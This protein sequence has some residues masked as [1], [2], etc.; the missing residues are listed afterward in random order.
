MRRLTGPQVTRLGRTVNDLRK[1]TTSE[2]LS[3]RAKQLVKKWQKLVKSDCA[4][5]ASTPNGLPFNPS[6]T[7]ALLKKAAAEVSK[8]AGATAVSGGTEEDSTKHTRHHPASSDGADSLSAS[9]ASNSAKV[10][11]ASGPSVNLPEYELTA[12]GHAVSAPVVPEPT[13]ERPDGPSWSRQ[14]HGVDGRWTQPDHKWT[15][16]TDPLPSEDG[17]TVAAPYVYLE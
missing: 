2:E 8:G 14:W 13:V 3:K 9:Q 12:S 7:T 17:S 1:K 6:N 5:R 16:W 4:S 11:E 15:G 10:A